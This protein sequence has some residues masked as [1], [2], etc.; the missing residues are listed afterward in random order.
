MR[1]SALVAANAFVGP[2]ARWV[3]SAAACFSRSVSSTTLLTTFHCR[4]CSAVVGSERNTISAALARPTRSAICIMPPCRV[5]MPT[6]ASGNAKR[7]GP[8]GEDQIA[9]QGELEPT[10]HASSLHG[11]DGWNRQ[12][13]QMVQRL[14]EHLYLWPQDLCGNA[15]PVAYLPAK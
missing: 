1:Q 14:G 11:S 8:G 9:T 5:T 10:A 7:A 12:A 2:S 15:W 13:F 6:R 3:A 4:I